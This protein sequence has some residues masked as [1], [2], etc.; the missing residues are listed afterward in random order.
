[1]AGK[2]SCPTVLIVDD[3][4]IIVLALT[5]L[6]SD[7]G[8]EVCG[9]ATTAPEALRLAA[10]LAPGLITMDINLGSPGEGFAAVT[11]IRTSDL[12]TPVLFITGGAE[13]DSGESIRALGR[14]EYVQK[15]FGPADIVAALARLALDEDG[16][17]YDEDDPA[18]N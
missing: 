15:P 10:R 1:M 11:L 13:A 4:E 17:G 8:Y 14:A 7:L 6:F 9:S 3:E 5:A 16:E 18:L 2:P 12:T